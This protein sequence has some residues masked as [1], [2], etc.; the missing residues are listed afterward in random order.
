MDRIVMRAS[1]AMFATLRLICRPGLGSSD[2]EGRMLLVARRVRSVRATTS[3]M[4]AT[5]AED[6]NHFSPLG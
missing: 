2:D 3:A 4:L 6:E 1:I 5:L